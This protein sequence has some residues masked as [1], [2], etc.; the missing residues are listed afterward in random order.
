MFGGCIS[1]FYELFYHLESQL[2]LDPN[3]DAHLWC[4]HYVFLDMINEHLTRWQRAYIHHP[5][6]SENNKTPMQLWV[7][8][9][10]EARGSGRAED[11]EFQV[12]VFICLL[13]QKVAHMY[14]LTLNFTYDQFVS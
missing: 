4:L 13:F 2:L 12:V 6:S 8:G 5:L 9:L 3:E 11:I 7:R 14:D 10:Q 1:F